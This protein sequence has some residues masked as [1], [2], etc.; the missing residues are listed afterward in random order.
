MT[1]NE[2]GLQAIELFKNKAKLCDSRP[3]KVA[4]NHRIGSDG[5]SASPSSSASASA[6]SSS[7]SVSSGPS[8][9]GT[10]SSGATATASIACQSE[11]S[12]LS[13]DVTQKD[14]S[15]VPST[16]SLSAQVC[17]QVTTITTPSRSRGSTVKSTTPAV[18]TGTYLAAPLNMY[19]MLHNSLLYW[20]RCVS[21]IWVCFSSS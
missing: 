5:A 3:S 17:N 14:M 16:S 18:A 4:R 13:C 11:A 8:T 21:L 1:R 20:V 15:T 19:Y 12:A 7:S 6:A 10:Q 2:A 9:S